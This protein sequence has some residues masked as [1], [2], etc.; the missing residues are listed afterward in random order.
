M[1]RAT[2]TT[3]NSP[4]LP[5]SLLFCRLCESWHYPKPKQCP[6]AALAA[7]RTPE[8]ALLASRLRVRLHQRASSPRSCEFGQA[9]LRHRM[10]QAPTDSC[11]DS[12]EPTPLVARFVWPNRK[13]ETRPGKNRPHPEKLI[14]LALLW[15]RLPGSWRASPGCVRQ[16]CGTFF[17]RVTQPDQI[18][19]QGRQRNLLP[20][21]LFQSLG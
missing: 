3:A 9:S 14:F 21:L 18:A 5:R 6:P 2:G 11:H 1:N 7:T 16:R 12:A 15:R 17:I 19:L 20:R 8:I 13:T 10:H 4:P